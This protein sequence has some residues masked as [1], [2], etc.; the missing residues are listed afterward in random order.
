MLKEPIQVI[1]RQTFPSG[2]LPN[3]F[4]KMTL[5]D[6]SSFEKNYLKIPVVATFLRCVN[7]I[8]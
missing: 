4:L 7:L 2:I 3:I 8:R 1:Q 5:K 6:Q